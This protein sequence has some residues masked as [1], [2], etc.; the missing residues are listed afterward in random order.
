M[1]NMKKIRLVVFPAVALLHV[2]L[3]F[4]LVFTMN[5][6]A[7]ETEPLAEIMKLVYVQEETP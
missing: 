6:I 1:I 5:T 2:C 3:I 7:S 4:F